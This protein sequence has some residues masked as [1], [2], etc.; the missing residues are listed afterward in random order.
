MRRASMST[1]TR[2]AWSG[3]P[4]AARCVRHDDR[5][6]G[7]GGRAV[8]RGRARRLRLGALRPAAAYPH[9]PSYE[10]R[11][12]VVVAVSR[13]ARLHLVGHRRPPQAVDAC[14]PRAPSTLSGDPR[15][16]SPESWTTVWT[17]Q[18]AVVEGADLTW[19]A[20]GCH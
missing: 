10:R 7:P 20:S 4:P 1:A 18:A 3:S 11:Q 6:L 9:P 5:P 19:V 13:C 17:S 8:G 12:L 14:F 2:L 15:A 16:G